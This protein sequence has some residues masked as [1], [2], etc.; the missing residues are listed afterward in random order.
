M[1]IGEVWKCGKEPT[2]HMCNWAHASL[3]FC[4]KVSAVILVNHVVG[5]K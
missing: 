5:N 1:K 4:V 3:L 2:A